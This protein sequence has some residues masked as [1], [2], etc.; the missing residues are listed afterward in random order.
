MDLDTQLA[1]LEDAPLPVIAFSDARLVWAN[2]LAADL[3]G[4]KTWLGQPLSILPAQWQAMLQAGEPGRIESGEKTAQFVRPLQ[5]SIGQLSLCYLIDITAEQELRDRVRV[6]TQEI[7]LKTQRDEQTGLMNRVDLRQLLEAEVARSRRYNNPLSLIRIDLDGLDSDDADPAIVLRAIGYLLNDRM[8]WADMIGCIEEHIVLIVL[9][10]TSEQIA[11][12]LTGKIR[13][14]MSALPVNN[15]P[16]SV[17]CR[18]GAAA[19]Q[20][21]DDS[22]TLL[23]RLEQAVTDQSTA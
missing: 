17:A 2:R 9:P 6:L 16:V 12:E 18:I 11:Q 15:R 5:Y 21:G 4:M 13:D 7:E 14:W 19:W 10:E 3:P 1:V 23:L 22:K 20:K 8:R